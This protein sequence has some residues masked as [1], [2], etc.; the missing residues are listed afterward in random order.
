MCATPP[1]NRRRFSIPKHLRSP[2]VIYKNRSS[3]GSSGGYEHTFS[4]KFIKQL[5]HIRK[6]LWCRFLSPL[7]IKDLAPQ[8]LITC[9]LTFFTSFTV[10]SEAFFNKNFSG[11]SSMNSSANSDSGLLANTSPT[12]S[13]IKVKHGKENKLQRFGGAVVNGG[14]LVFGKIKSLWSHS[15]GHALG[16]NILADSD[17]HRTSKSKENLGPTQSL[18]LRVF[19]FFCREISA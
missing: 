16:L 17:R 19:W 4:G 6:Q 13:I 15:S 7:F 11:V 10:Q 2:F 5:R 3:N 1:Q 9:V 18:L 12:Q 8:P 14:S